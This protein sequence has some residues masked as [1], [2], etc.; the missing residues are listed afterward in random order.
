[1]TAICNTLAIQ[2]DCAASGIYHSIYIYVWTALIKMDWLLN[3]ISRISPARPLRPEVTM[4]GTVIH[5]YFKRFCYQFINVPKNMSL[6]WFNL[7]CLP[8]DLT[9]AAFSILCNFTDK[10]CHLTIWTVSKLIYISLSG[11]CNIL[12]FCIKF[13]KFIMWIIACDI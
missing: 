13:V 3:I 5:E 2:Y 12:I 11:D 4:V 7:T 10:P 1:M 6:S 8:F 9:N